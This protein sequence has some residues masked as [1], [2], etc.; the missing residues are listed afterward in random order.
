MKNSRMIEYSFEFVFCPLYGVL[1]QEKRHL[2]IRDR[3]R[4]CFFF[5]GECALPL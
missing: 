5:G 2:K 4:E 1:M 3:S